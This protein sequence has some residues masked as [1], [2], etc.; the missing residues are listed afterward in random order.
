M[1][2]TDPGQQKPGT[3]AARSR[4]LPVRREHRMSIRGFF[5]HESRPTR[6]FDQMN[7][8]TCDF[9][10]IHAGEL[11]HTH[12]LLGSFSA[13][14]ALK[15]WSLYDIL[16]VRRVSPPPQGGFCGVLGETQFLSCP[17]IPIPSTLSGSRIGHHSPRLTPSKSVSRFFTSIN[18]HLEWAGVH[19]LSA[20]S[21][22]RQKNKMVSRSKPMSRSRV[23]N[24]VP[25][26]CHTPG[27]LEMSRK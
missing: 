18:L 16:P 26:K 8:D 25:M 4:L 23:L 11:E 15:A 13:K 9:F 10:S 1:R 24:T 27:A 14:T 5:S 3:P 12:N 21:Y 20:I 2:K 7:S 19:H 17:R 6:Q 22:A